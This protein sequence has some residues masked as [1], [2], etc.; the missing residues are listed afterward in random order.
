MGKFYKNE[1]IEYSL[2]GQ[3]KPETLI[4]TEGPTESYF[5]EKW[6]LSA[7][8]DSKKIA[9]ICFK[10]KQK[11]TAVFK[12]FMMEENFPSITR[13]GFFLDAEAQQAVSSIHSIQT[14]LRDVQLISRNS[15]LSA[16]CQNIG[17]RI[18]ALYVSPNNADSG[19]IEH[20]VIN[21]IAGSEL[22]TCLQSFKAEVETKLGHD[23][24]PKSIVQAYIGVRSPGTC[25]TG[26]GFNKELLDV[27]H[28][29]YDELRRVMGQL[30][31]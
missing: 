24:H 13:F 5:M 19:M 6:L 26:H 15:S 14:L 28:A 21:E 3:E 4:F 1:S 23:L 20:M 17:G 31:L 12:K 18:F 27:N 9:V 25:G 7:N 2:R 29:A 22:N 16:G 8:K 10:G 30:C 11:L